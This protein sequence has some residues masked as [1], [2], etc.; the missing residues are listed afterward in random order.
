MRFEITNKY[1]E[2]DLQAQFDFYYKLC[3]FSIFGVDPENES[4]EEEK[5]AVKKMADEARI[6]NSAK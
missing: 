1:P 4:L 3:M 5:E 2:E 6:R